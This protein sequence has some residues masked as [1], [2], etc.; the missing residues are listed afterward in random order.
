MKI[1]NT[2]G[3]SVTVVSRQYSGEG[4]IILNTDISNAVLKVHPVLCRREASLSRNDF[5]PQ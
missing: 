1:I 3:K 5:F 2:R 4:Y